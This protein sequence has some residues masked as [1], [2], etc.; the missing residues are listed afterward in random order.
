[1]LERRATA[2]NEVLASGSPLGIVDLRKF[3]R[4]D[5]EVFDSLSL[6]L[7]AF[8][9]SLAIVPASRAVYSESTEPWQEFGGS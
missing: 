4:E 3:V 8:G 5:A 6:V 9:L 2:N 7:A 1:M